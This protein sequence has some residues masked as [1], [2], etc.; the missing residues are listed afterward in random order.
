MEVTNSE[1]RSSLLL[2]GI[3]NVLKEITLQAPGVAITSRH[4][5]LQVGPISLSVFPWQGFSA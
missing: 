1:E 2:P 4:C 3:N 5:G